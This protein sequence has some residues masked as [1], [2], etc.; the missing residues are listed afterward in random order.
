MGMPKMSSL[1]H[2]WHK[3][4]ATGFTARIAVTCWPLF[5]VGPMPT[6][7]ANEGQANRY[8]GH[9]HTFS[10]IQSASIP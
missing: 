10:R 4:C 8:A 7:H 6:D 5:P 1:T 2:P 3:A 9:P